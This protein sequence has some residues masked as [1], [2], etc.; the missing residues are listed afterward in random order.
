MDKTQALN[1]LPHL[2]SPAALA[3][4]D[5]GGKWRNPPHLRAINAALMRWWGIPNSRGAVSVPFQH[6]KTVLCSN[7]FPAWVLLLW[8]ETRIALASYS[9][10]YAAKQGAAVREIVARYG[11]AL[12]VSLREDTRAKDEWVVDFTGGGGDRNNWLAGGMVCK[13]RGGALTGRAADLLI[14]DDMIK[15]CTV[16][17]SRLGPTAPVISVSTRWGPKDLVGRWES[18]AKVGG[19]QFEHVVFPAIAEKNDLLGRKPGE[20]L[21]PERVPLNRLEMIRK[22]RPRWF[23]A[24]WQGKPVEGIGLHFQPKNWPRYVDTGDAW[25]FKVGFSYNSYRKAECYALI[26]VDWAQRGKKDSDKTA[27]VAAALT[28]DGYVLVLDTFNQQLRQEG[29]AP[30]LAAWCQR[31]RWSDIAGLIVASDDDML[32]EAMVIACRQH[33][34]IPDIKRL[35]IRSRSKLIRAQASIMRSQDG[36]FL[37]PEREEEWYAEFEEQLRTFTGAEGAEDDIV[38]CVGILGRLANDWYPAE[39]YEEDYEPLLGSGGYLSAF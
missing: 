4:A 7:Y 33:R 30:A 26:A 8:P 39:V 23:E 20:A 1:R 14:L 37:L 25:R 6:G 9:D 18:E 3:T 19:E 5:S 22:R 35:G 38:D 16:A 31:W 21:W 27:F 24:C 15:N 12:G 2:A 34:A 28:P 10:E 11:P 17:F 36:K 29:N 32:S 13:G